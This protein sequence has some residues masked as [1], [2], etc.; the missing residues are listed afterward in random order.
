V[1]GDRLWFAV[2][3][4]GCCIKYREPRTS[5]AKGPTALAHG[6][7]RVRSRQAVCGTWETAS[8]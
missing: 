1:R 7:A 2:V 4:H 6:G 3:V 5:H 8:W